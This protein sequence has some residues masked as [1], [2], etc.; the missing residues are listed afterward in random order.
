MLGTTFTNKWKRKRQKRL[1]QV[2]GLEKLF[3]PKT[4]AIKDAIKTIAVTRG[5]KVYA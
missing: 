5:H 4:Q 2:P 3:D 1:L